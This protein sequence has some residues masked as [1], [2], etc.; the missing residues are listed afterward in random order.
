VTYLARCTN[1][2]ET[3]HSWSI[4][5]VI[6]ISRCV[7]KMSTTK[8][9]GFIFWTTLYV[10]LLVACNWRPFRQTRWEWKALKAYPHWHFFSFWATLYVGLSNWRPFRQT[11]WEWKAWKA[12]PHLHFLGHPVRWSWQLTT[13]RTDKMGMKSLKG[14]STLTLFGPPCTLVLAIDDLSDRQDGNEKL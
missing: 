9:S 5:K 10:G 12:Y 4:S 1:V 2:F 13:F 11:R 6:Q 7:L 8:E 3:K 14:L